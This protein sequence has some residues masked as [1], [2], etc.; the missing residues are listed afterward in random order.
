M[1]AILLSAA[2]MAGTLASC[3]P[4]DVVNGS[5]SVAREQSSEGNSEAASGSAAEPTVNPNPTPTPEVTPSPEEL[6]EQREKELREKLDNGKWKWKKKRVFYLDA[7]GKKVTGLATIKKKTYFFDKKGVQRTGWWKIK[8]NYYFFRLKNEAK[9]HMVKDKTVNL[10]KL[11]KSG[12]ARVKAKWKQKKVWTMWKC[13]KI[14]A[15]ITNAAMTVD[16]KLRAAYDYERKA[17]WILGSHTFY[18]LK[19]F[20]VY[21]A[22]DMMTKGHAACYG[23]GA[24]FAYLA[25]AAGAKKCAAVSSG[26]HGWAEVNGLVS[27]P[28]WEFANKSNSYF[29]FPY[30]LSGVNGRPPYKNCRSH[31]KYV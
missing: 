3:A 30:S 21:Y 31:V 26:G 9:G 18:N 8:D 5:K 24:L 4:E 14:L 22:Y 29:Q 11:R 2:V 6:A 15:K 23:W 25:N 20:D 13:S 16:Q 7:D 12:K 27:D 28:N 1:I 19:H 10:I 17:F